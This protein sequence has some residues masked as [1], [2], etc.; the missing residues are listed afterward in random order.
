M[1]I[2]LPSLY[3]T[4]D[5]GQPVTIASAAETQI[6]VLEGRVWLTEEGLS[7]DIFLFPGA[8]YRLRTTGRV[9]LDCDSPSRL[10]IQAPVAVH[11]D[12][13][14]SQ[15]LAGRVLAAVQSLRGRAVAGAPGEVGGCH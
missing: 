15:R 2:K 9:V 6:R 1:R 3:L 8:Q 13:P 10:E 5:A 14:P 4:L 12:S 11:T 7:E